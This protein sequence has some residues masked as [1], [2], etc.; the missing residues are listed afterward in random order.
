MGELRQR[1]DKK[2]RAGIRAQFLQPGA[3]R[4][5][6]VSALP[7]AAAAVIERAA[8]AKVQLGILLDTGRQHR[9]G[10]EPHEA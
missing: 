1:D 10:L 8:G 7:A 4:H 5:I 9:S 6:D 3:I 2:I